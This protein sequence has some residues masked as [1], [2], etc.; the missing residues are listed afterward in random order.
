MDGLPVTVAE[1]QGGQMTQKPLEQER[2]ST[3]AWEAKQKDSA[4]ADEPHNY[5]ELQ[6]ERKG[7]FGRKID[8]F[9]HDS[10]FGCN[11]ERLPCHPA[12]THPC[13]H[14]FHP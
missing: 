4:G 2:R 1:L 8:R 9:S 7:C 14:R 6:I 12:H 10:R 11:G 5:Q 3:E 13:S